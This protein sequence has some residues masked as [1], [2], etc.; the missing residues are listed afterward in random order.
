MNILI[1]SIVSISLFI[2]SVITNVSFSQ[3]TGTLKD[4][5]GEIMRGYPMIISKQWSNTTQFTLNPANWQ[6][7]KDSSR[8][9][10]RLCWVGPWVEDRMDEPG[11]ESLAGVWTLDSV[12]MIIDSCVSIATDKQM[13]IIINYHN[14]GEQQNK[15]GFV[16]PQDVNMERLTEFWAKV[17]P[18]YRGNDLVYYELANEPSFKKDAYTEPN[19]MSKFISVYNTVR[20][21]APEQQILMFSF[22]SMNFNF[23]E[24]M[25]V[26]DP[27]MDWDHTS[28]AYHM[29]STASSE[30]IVKL[31]QTHQVI[32]T[33]W[34]YP[35]SGQNYVVQVDGYELN[36]QTLEAIGHSWCDWHNW[37]DD[38]FNLTFN[39]LNS[40]ARAKGYAWWLVRKPD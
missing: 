10:V 26:Y 35:S 18:R 2:L 29:Y 6:T 39:E 19:F 3:N 22:N 23:K 30:P 11:F 33:E 12:A 25:A 40:D 14:V 9:T 15:D 36:A 32:C 1:S 13:N 16:S 21:L 4:K 27:Y 31:S 24:I 37:S 20:T 34:H 7:L 38:S 5:N 28:V 8:N 17:A